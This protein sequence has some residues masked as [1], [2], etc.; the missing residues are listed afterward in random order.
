MTKKV[1]LI[2][3]GALILVI[4]VLLLR[5]GIVP[6]APARA[7]RDYSNEY[8]FTN[9]ILDYENPK[10]SSVSLF[11]ESVESKV[12]DLKKRYGLDFAS[13]YFRD[14]DDGQWIGVN[15]KEA[16][17]SASLVKLPI[18]ISLLKDA[19]TRP[20]FLEQRVAVTAADAGADLRQN[21]KP[22]RPVMPG[23]TYTLG[24]LAERMIVESDNVAAAA[25]IRA[26]DENREQIYRAVGVKFH[27]EE[28]EVMVN[29]KNYAGFFRVLFNATYLSRENSEKALGILSKVKFTQGIVAG[30]PAGT[31]V[32][33]KFGE[34]SV[35]INGLE[36]Q[37]QLHDCG[38]VYYP[39]NPYLLCIMTRGNNFDNQEKFIA[40]VSRYF[41]AE[42]RKSL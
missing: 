9:P 42:V 13:V 24:E 10:M 5:I 14:L 31:P 38:I 16:L 27:D 23:E 6:A 36:G 29:V 2:S 8:K 33:H 3:H 18:L 32:A 19:E 34:R 7:S 15:E 20:G 4:I 40:E 21:I 1:L 11:S 26:T 35:T 12:H 37:T 39:E 28:D 17:A 30:V 25:I 22:D 41:Y